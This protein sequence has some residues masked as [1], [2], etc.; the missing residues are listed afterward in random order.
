MIETGS[1]SCNMN[2]SDKPVAYIKRGK[3]FEL[4]DF[5]LDNK[6]DFSVTERTVGIDEY[7][8]TL[9]ITQVKKAIQFGIYVRENRLELAGMTQEKPVTK[10]STNNKKTAEVQLAK[11]EEVPTP[12]SPVIH[13]QP[14]KVE[15][16]NTSSNTTSPIS[17]DE[18]SLSLSFD[19][20]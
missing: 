19:L 3:L 15:P 1:Y 5:C 18:S 7:E 14:Q 10:K 2:Q 12:T 16:E 17:G 8:V 11:N 9:D 20:N 13:E 4:I 6:I